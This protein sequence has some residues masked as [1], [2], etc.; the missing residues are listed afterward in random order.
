MLPPNKRL[1][2]TA[3]L[4]SS[5][6][7]FCR[8]AEF[9]RAPQLKRSVGWLTVTM[10]K[11]KTHVYAIIRVDEFYNQSTPIESRDSNVVVNYP[12]FNIVILAAPSAES[13]ADCSE[14]RRV[15]R[16]KGW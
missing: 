9:L 10:G 5:Q 12:S 16:D 15:A 8:S 6:V 14:A 7:V 13:D 3:R 1:Q 11:A 4:H 2:L